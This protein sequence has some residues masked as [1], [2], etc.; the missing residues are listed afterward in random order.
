MYYL[1]ALTLLNTQFLGDVAH[2]TPLVA[3]HQQGV[4][5]LPSTAHTSG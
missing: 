1:S 2:S 4:G 3:V 5:L